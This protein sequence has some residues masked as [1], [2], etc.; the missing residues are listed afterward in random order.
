MLSK[1]EWYTAGCSDTCK[2]SFKTGV[3]GSS[4]ENVYFGSDAE[5]LRSN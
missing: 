3:D 5:E 2:I 4:T 1:D